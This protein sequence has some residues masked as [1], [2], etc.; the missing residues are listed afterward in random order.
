VTKENLDL[1]WRTGGYHICNLP[2]CDH[3]L[4]LRLMHGL[5]LGSWLIWV[6][7]PRE[8]KTL[9]CAP[10]LVLHYVLEH[11]YLPPRD[12][13]EAVLTYRPGDLPIRSGRYGLRLR[14]PEEMPPTLPVRSPLEAIGRDVFKLAE[15][16]VMRLRCP[17][18]G[19]LRISYTRTQERAYSMIRCLGCGAWQHG[20]HGV[21]RPEHAPVWAR[22]VGPRASKE[23]L[24][25]DDVD[26]APG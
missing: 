18:G 4:G 1:G 8:P 21:Y 3:K 20:N 24:T 26:E 15:R 14:S 9:L 17:C 6:R 22:E 7:H 12:F 10:D 5:R 25:G 16:E 11:H 19:G 13:I 23:I 2:D